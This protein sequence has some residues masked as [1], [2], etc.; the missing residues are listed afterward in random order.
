MKSRLLRK[1]LK[2][3]RKNDTKILAG[4]AIIGSIITPILASK[5]TVKAH[6]EL[7]KLDEE[8]AELQRFLN[9]T[10]RGQI[11]TSTI[12][13]DGYTGDGRE[14]GTALGIPSPIERHEDVA[15]NYANYTIFDIRFF[16]DP[17]IITCIL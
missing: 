3:V 7:K 12:A 9:L 13:R 8:A 1:T 6:E 2:F 10:D 14:M 16:L 17:V 15:Y 11:L 4:L 5:A